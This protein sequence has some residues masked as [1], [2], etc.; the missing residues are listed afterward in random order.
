MVL[1]SYKQTGHY[2]FV[3]SSICAF[4][5]IGNKY[6]QTSSNYLSSKFL[7][8]LIAA[9]AVFTS[10]YSSLISFSLSFLFS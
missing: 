2:I 7:Y 9:G 5:F 4:S 3:S 1:Y 10:P 8:P 6:L